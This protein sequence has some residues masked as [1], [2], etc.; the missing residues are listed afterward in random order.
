MTN[1]VAEGVGSFLFGHNL[2]EQGTGLREV[3]VGVSGFETADQTSNSLG[4]ELGFGSHL[5][6]VE[7]GGF[8]VNFGSLVTVDVHGTITLVVGDSSSVGAVDGDLVVVGTESVSVGIRI[9]EETTLEHLVQRGF[10][11]GN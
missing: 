4:G 10:H 9:R 8:V 7:G 6:T 2:S 5:V 1:D 3:V 11:T